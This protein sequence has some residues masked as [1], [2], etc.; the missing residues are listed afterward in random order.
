MNSRAKGKRGELDCRSLLREF[1][2]EAHRGQQHQGGAESPDVIHDIRRRHGAA[3]GLLVDH[4]DVIELA[5]AC[6]A[7]LIGTSCELTEKPNF[8]MSPRS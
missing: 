1:G 7:P 8:A 5:H 4:D 6:R 3:Q 2:Y